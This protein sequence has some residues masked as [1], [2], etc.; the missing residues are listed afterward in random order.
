MHTEL[1]STLSAPSLLTSGPASN[2]EALESKSERDEKVKLRDRNSCIKFLVN[3]WFMLSTI[4]GVCLGFGLGFIVRTTQPGPTV[5]T[6]IAMPSD[7]YLRLLQLT[8]LPLISSNILVA[9]ATLDFKR[10]GKVGIIGVVYIIA[11]NLGC[12]IIGAAC[13]LLI[14]PGSRILVGNA[15]GSS[16]VSTA[17]GL[18][19]SDVFRDLFYNLFPDNIF[20]IT[21][22]H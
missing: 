14:Q 22:Y 13:A 17:S 18:T 6:W 9:I 12:A 10:D 5:I 8:I 7:I 1:D 3:N 15:N 20:G 16:P 19:A 2:M 4:A 21:I 11:L